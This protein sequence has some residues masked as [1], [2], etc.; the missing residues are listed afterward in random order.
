MET[1]N[2]RIR[3]NLSQTAKGFV[4]FEVTAEFSTMEE[5]EK[6]LNEAVQAARRVMAANRLQEVGG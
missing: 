6:N 3:I 4:Q 5:T 2:K 1:E